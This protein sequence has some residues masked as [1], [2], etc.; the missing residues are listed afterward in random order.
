LP[1]NDFLNLNWAVG[2]RRQTAKEKAAAFRAAARK[3]T[4]R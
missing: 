4:Q 3:R 1:R 2:R